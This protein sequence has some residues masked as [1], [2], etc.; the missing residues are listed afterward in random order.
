[1]NCNREI[2]P[3]LACS[4]PGTPHIRTLAVRAEPVRRQNN[5]SQGFTILE[6]TIVTALISVLLVIGMISGTAANDRRKFQF[7]VER[8]ETTLR[9]CRAEAANSARRIRLSFDAETQLPTLLWEPSP[10]TEPGQFTAHKTCSW[11]NRIP[12]SGIAVTR[13]RTLGPDGKPVDEAPSSVSDEADE[14]EMQTITFGHDGT[15]D[16]VLI[17]IESSLE[18]D[19]FRAAI[20]LDGQNNLIKTKFMFGNTED[21]DEDDPFAEDEEEISE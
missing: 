8:L 18:G 21:D 12:K 6:L 5:C 4:S 7:T 20:K 13:C 3:G 15:S 17:E 10:L 9:M 19:S 16:S 14:E 1:M 11:L 2:S